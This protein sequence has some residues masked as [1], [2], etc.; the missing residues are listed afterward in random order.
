MHILKVTGI[1]WREGRFICKLYKDPSIKIR[2]D[3]GETRSVKIGRG[4]RTVC[5]LMSLLF[6]MYSEYLNR[7]LFKGLETSK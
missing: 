4:G 6:N 2:L 1:D 7:K 3:Q 5:C